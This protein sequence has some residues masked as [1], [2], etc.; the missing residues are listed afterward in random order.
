M[1][2]QSPTQESP[3]VRATRNALQEG[4]LSLLEELPISRITISMVCL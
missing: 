2:L 3:R 1:S 4:L